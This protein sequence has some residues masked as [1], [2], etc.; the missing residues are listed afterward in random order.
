MIANA[1]RGK[2]TRIETIAQDQTLE[3]GAALSQIVRDRAAKTV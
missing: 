1:V 2:F 3:E